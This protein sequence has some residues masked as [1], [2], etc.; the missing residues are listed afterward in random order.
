M[1]DNKLM[2]LL[3]N[4]EK[5]NRRQAV[6]TAILCVLLAVTAVCCIVV[7]TS[8]HSLVPQVDT[9]LAQMQTVLE[10]MQTVTEELAAADLEGMVK[11]IDTMVT[12]VDGFIG[13]AEGLAGNMDTLVATGQTSLEQTMAKLNAINFETLNKAIEDLA[14]VVEPIANFF[15]KLR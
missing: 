13:T 5:T 3:Q 9:A 12:D 6:G 10:D 4:I 14:A 11:N 8:I 7:F 15:N 1:E 2:Q